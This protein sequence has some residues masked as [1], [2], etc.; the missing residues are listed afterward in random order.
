MLIYFSYTPTPFVRISFWSSVIGQGVSWFYM[1]IRQ[2]HLQ[3][4]VSTSNAS[5]GR[6]YVLNRLRFDNIHISSHL[7][8]FNFS[9]AVFH[10]G[11][12]PIDLLYIYSSPFD[13]FIQ[14]FRTCI[15]NII[16]CLD[17]RWFI[18]QYHTSLQGHAIE[19]T[20]KFDN[21]CHCVPLWHHSLCLLRAIGM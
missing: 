14:L 6:R 8:H 10:Q 16:K 11:I 20:F 17:N 2:N 1:P 7:F 12:L 13:P 21:V 18:R 9:C 15:Y 19:Y 3:R 5:D 4:I